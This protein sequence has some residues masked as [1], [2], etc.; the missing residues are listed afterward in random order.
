MSDPQ[1]YAYPV[2][3]AVR[4]FGISRSRLYELLHA[5]RIS[6]KKE[7]SRTLILAD[8]LKEYVES[9]PAWSPQDDDPHP[10]NQTPVH[11]SRQAR[12]TKGLDT[13]PS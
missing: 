11:P 3:D 5:G 13:N 8:S 10:Q 9:L 1:P 7:G 2:K 6:A 12:G 4:D